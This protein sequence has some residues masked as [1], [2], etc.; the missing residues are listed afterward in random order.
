[1]LIF[2]SYKVGQTFK[3]LTSEKFYI[4]T[5]NGKEGV[6]KTQLR[7]SLLLLKGKKKEEENALPSSHLASQ[8]A[9]AL[10]PACAALRCKEEQFP[11][12]ISIISICCSSSPRL[13]P[14][15]V[16]LPPRRLPGL[17]HRR[18]PAEHRRPPRRLR[19]STLHPPCE[20]LSLRSSPT[21]LFYFPFAC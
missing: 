4:E 13:L 1:M 12:P 3:S 9:P 5:K 10:Q 21:R 11:A 8:S 2:F 6:L 17:T 20:L 18:L 19:K 16:S 15:F 14:H 7:A